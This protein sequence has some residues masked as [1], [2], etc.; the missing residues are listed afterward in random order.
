VVV[1]YEN[2]IAMAKTLEGALAAIFSPQTPSPT[3][4]LRQVQEPTIAP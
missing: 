2:Q 1:V 4:I 3:T